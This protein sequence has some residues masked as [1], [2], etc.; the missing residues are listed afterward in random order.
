MKKKLAVL[1]LLSVASLALS[2]A[3]AH[4]FFWHHWCKRCYTTQINCRPYNAF[5]PICSGNLTCDGVC[6]NPCAMAAGCCNFPNYG[7]GMPAPVFGGFCG[8]GACAMLP[9]FGGGGAQLPMTFA[10]TQV[11]M[12]MPANYAPVP[13][14]VPTPGGVT[15]F[16]APQYGAPA[17]YGY[18]VQPTGYQPNYYGYNPYQFASQN[19]YGYA[20]AWPTQPA[21]QF[22]YG[23]GKQR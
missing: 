14:P 16:G 5:T 9:S 2:A 22:G 23:Y 19:P 10:P 17:H 21:F 4:A 11:P 3:H 8:D 6:P 18:N 12:Q 1:A 13:A 20:P 7:Y 15:Q